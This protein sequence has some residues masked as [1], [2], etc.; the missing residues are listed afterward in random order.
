MR[1]YTY[2]SIVVHHSPVCSVFMYVY[3]FR[4]RVFILAYIGGVDGREL[5]RLYSS[6]SSVSFPVAAVELKLSKSLTSLGHG[7]KHRDRMR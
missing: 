7:G 2:I 6:I 1:I 4:S 3:A 5:L